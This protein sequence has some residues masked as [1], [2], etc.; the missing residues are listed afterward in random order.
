MIHTPGDG[1]AF[2][3]QAS[4]PA[5]VGQ[6]DGVVDFEVVGKAASDTGATVIL[7]RPPFASEAQ[8]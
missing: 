4:E 7:G 8:S 3:R 1:D 2:Y 6:H 5:H